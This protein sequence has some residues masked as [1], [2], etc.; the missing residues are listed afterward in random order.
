MVFFSHTRTLRHA[1][2]RA[3]KRVKAWELKLS[4]LWPLLRMYPQIKVRFFCF[5]I[6]PGQ[7]HSM[8][9]AA[10]RQ[11]QLPAQTLHHCLHPPPPIDRTCPPLQVT[12]L[13]YMRHRL[14]RDLGSYTAPPNHYCELTAIIS[15]GLMK[16][17]SSAAKL[18]ELVLELVKARDRCSNTHA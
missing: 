4:D 2:Y 1:S 8:H 10:V 6:H 16:P 3:I 13:D 5:P 12:M 14:C 18:E 17:G 7:G 9:S 11:A 15:S